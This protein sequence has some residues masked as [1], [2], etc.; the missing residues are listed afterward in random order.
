MAKSVL[1]RGLL[2]H[3]EW[4]HIHCSQEVA[5]GNFTKTKTRPSFS[6]VVSHDKF[7]RLLVEKTV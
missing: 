4:Q 2:A 1:K 3:F 5:R 7:L 6:A